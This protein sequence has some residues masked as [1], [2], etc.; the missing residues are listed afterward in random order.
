MTSVSERLYL[1]TDRRVCGGT[2]GL[3]ARLSAALRG[4]PRGSVIVQLREKDLETGALIALGLRIRALCTESGARLLVNRRADVARAISAEGVHLPDV[5]GDVA[6][7]RAALGGNGLIAASTHTPGRA[8]TQS[9]AGADLIVLGPMWETLSKAGP[10]APAPLGPESLSEAASL[11]SGPTRLFALGGV[12]TA[13][14]AREAIRAGAHGVAAIRGVLAVDDPGAA[15]A[16][17]VA[18]VEET[19][20][21]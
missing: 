12:D 4:A 14:R 3:V 1:I 18:A 11:M 21:W 7:A 10:G 19:R 9:M 20:G 16:A 6:A 2:E 15:A 17:L 13:A 5:G 8:A